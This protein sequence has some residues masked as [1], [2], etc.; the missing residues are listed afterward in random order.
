MVARLTENSAASSAIVWS[1]AAWSLSRTARLVGLSLGAL[2]LEPAFGAG[3]R[4]AFAG[5]HP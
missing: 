5:A 4:H 2:P 3:D 1:P